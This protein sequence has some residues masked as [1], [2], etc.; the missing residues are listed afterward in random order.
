VGDIPRAR[1]RGARRAHRRV[2][3]RLRGDAHRRVT[4]SPGVIP[5]PCGAL[6]DR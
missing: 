1:D 6:R 4:R 2:P 5:T 3:H